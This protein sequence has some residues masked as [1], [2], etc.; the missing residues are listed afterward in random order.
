MLFAHATY[1]RSNNPSFLAWIVDLD[2][3]FFFK[4]NSLG[5]RIIQ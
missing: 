2:F 1:T 5:G 3:Y 4:I